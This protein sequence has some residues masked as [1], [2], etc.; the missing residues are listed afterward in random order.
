MRRTD[1]SNFTSSNAKRAC[2]CALALALCTP[3]A[4]STMPSE[5]M[6]DEDQSTLERLESLKSEANSIKSSIDALQ[7]EL[8]QVMDEYNTA[9]SERRAAM[10]A[11]RESKVKMDRAQ[12]EMLELQEQIEA[13]AQTMYKSDKSGASS[14][15]MN[16]LLGS[17]NFSDFMLGLD[18]MERV[19]ESH[20][21]LVEECRQ[22]KAEAEAAHAEFDAQKAEADAKL[23]VAEAKKLEISEKQGKLSAQAASVATQISE[24]EAQAELEEEEARRA[25][26]AAK[27]ASRAFAASL[28]A[29]EGR[30]VGNGFFANPC[31]TAWESS[32]YGWREMDQKFHLGTDMAANM[33]DPIYAG[34]AGTVIAATYDGSYNGSVGNWVVISHGNGLVTK[35]MHCSAVF[36]DIGQRVERGQHIAAVGSTGRSTG[37]HLHFQVE[38]NGVAVCPYDYL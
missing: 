1:I 13:L 37:P 8:N 29:G 6:A 16:V 36:V 3:F 38:V 24:T 33:G 34:E 9:T 7:T 10:K 11:M 22:V 27:A 4:V 20:A 18:M 17:T 21:E 14:S 5:A 2:A 25:E 19:S 12:A 35:Y 30:D 31:P 32:G 28:A 23:E 26:E 15:Y